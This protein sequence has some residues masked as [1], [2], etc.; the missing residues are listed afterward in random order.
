MKVN[1][2]TVNGQ[3]KQ[4]QQKSQR[5][6]VKVNVHPRDLCQKMQI[7]EIKVLG[8]F[9]VN[10][11]KHWPKSTLVNSALKNPRLDEW[12]WPPML[13]YLYP[14]VR[15]CDTTAGASSL[16]FISGRPAHI[17]NKF[18]INV[19]LIESRWSLDR[20]CT[21]PKEESSKNIG[22][23]TWVPQHGVWT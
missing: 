7:D 5:S 11:T 18:K 8:E 20:S 6:Q 1:V 12:K 3:R 9:R 22:I 17:L 21:S 14:S 13:T 2:V 19:L 23:F 15:V 4:Q 10:L 16:H